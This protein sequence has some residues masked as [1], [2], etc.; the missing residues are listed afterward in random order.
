M[1]SS[2]AA[3][4]AAL[5]LLLPHAAHAA[6]GA[7]NSTLIP[8]DLSVASDFYMSFG[9]GTRIAD[10]AKDWPWPDGSV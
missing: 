6:C 1:P 9:N 2:P 4:A 5:F 3:L 8:I 10:D 7:A